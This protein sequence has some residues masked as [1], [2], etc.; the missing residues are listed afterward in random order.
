[1]EDYRS[2]TEEEIEQLQKQG[3]SAEDWT[4]INVAEDFTAD[5]IINTDF[6]GDINL[7][8]FEK[9]IEIYEDFAKHSGIKN[10]V[11]KNVTI[12]DNC[13]I[14]GI[15]NFISNY[16]IGEECYISNVGKI[17]AT[18]DA[19]F[20]EGN[21]ISVQNEGGDGNIIIFD[22]LTSQLS[23][24]M[25]RH[26]N[27]KELRNA[28]LDVIKQYIAYQKPSHGIIG[29]RVKIINTTEVNNTIIND[30]CEV[31]GASRISD[32]SILSTTDSSTFIGN[33]VLLDSTIVQPGSSILD[34]AKVD[35]CFVG[36]ACHI[37]KG[38]SAEAS[39]FFANSYLD[40]GEACAAF[41]GPFTVSHHKSSL[42]IGGEYSFY[43]AGS[44]TNFSNHAYKMGPI[45]W[46]SMERGSKTASGAHILWPATI[47]T[48]T[49]C[50][51]KIQNH[52]RIKDLPF[53]YVFGQGDG[54]YVAPGRNFTTVGT[55]RDINKWPKRDMRPRNGQTSIV[56]FDWLSPLV[57]LECIKGRN[58]L[59]QLRKEQGENVASY[60][61]NGCIIKNQSLQRGIKFYSMA[62][63]L[64]I[65]NVLK[66]IENIELPESSIGTGEWNDLA[67]MYIPD[68]EELQLLEDIKNGA[69][70]D[71]NDIHERFEE[72]HRN[73]E[74]Y[75][76][77]FSY[78]IICNICHLEQLT[79][80]DATRIKAQCEP[81][82][83][84]W[85]TAIK[86]DA[87]KEFQLGDVSEEALNDFFE[88]M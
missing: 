58:I 61:Y 24:F 37:G 87:E 44:N 3:C 72:I 78:R 59:E 25:I 33:D 2:L 81:T 40:N 42:L 84:E 63:R 8:V 15:G 26:A 51:G 50:M 12:G 76:W 54:T 35:N 21:V 28:L 73:Y 7:G 71:I 29:Y 67:G 88:S 11:L 52:P 18:S 80:D 13:L 20:G 5:Y 32:C 86:Y 65:Y 22:G 75:K 49:M 60:T 62:I 34:G 23:A 36:E 38:A 45:H 85:K 48:F 83:E 10:A 19:T 55:W 56:N 79:D 4:A 16:E 74:T 39:I 70:A 53:S 17:S 43:N 66:E 69:L 68:T 14:E 27:D 1:M 9:N 82:Y 47:G 30:D 46:G 57:V 6:Y 64:Y 41:C 77:A 31:S